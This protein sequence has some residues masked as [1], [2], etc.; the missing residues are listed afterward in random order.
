MTSPQEIDSQLEREDILPY[1]NSIYDADLPESIIEQFRVA[2][3]VLPITAHKY[4]MKDVRTLST[5][6]AS[7]VTVRELGM[8]INV[9]F[10]VSFASM[11]G[12]LEEG[13]EKTIQFE[14]IKDEY[15][16]ATGA[17]ERKIQNKRA[18]LLKLSG[19][20]ESTAPFNGLHKSN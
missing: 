15:N 12:S 1:L 20:G 17:F 4:S 7:E 16:K 13:I 10:A 9:I 18:R 19:V 8:I 11:Y 5:R 14:K 6:R 2:M 3:M